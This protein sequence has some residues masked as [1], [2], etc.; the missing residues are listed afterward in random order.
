MAEIKQYID[1]LKQKQY[2]AIVN[3]KEYKALLKDMSQRISNK[4]KTA[5]NEATIESYFD[6]ELFAF[7]RDIFKPLGFEYNP[8]KEA[9][10]STKRHVTKGRADTS[11][12]ALVIEFKQPS[13]FSSKEQKN[14]AINQISEY[15]I[16]LDFEGESVGFVTDGT[17]CCFI[18]KN[19]NGLMR[20]GV[21]ELSFEQLDRLVQSIIR[22]S[23]TALTSKNI[24]ENFCNPPENDGI[25]FAL[26]K[27]LYDNLSKAITPKTQM[28]FNEWKELFNLAHDDVSKQQ[29]I[30]DRKTS[31]ENL[32]GK[33]FSKNDEEYT[34]L[35]AL[36]TAYAIIVKIV[37]Y[38]ILSIVRYNASLIDFETLVDCDSEALRYQ[39]ALLEEGAIF[40][41]Y[42]IT[43][44]LEGD[45]F[46]WYAAK[47]QW[48]IDISKSIADVF[49]VLSK[50]SDKAVLNT[51]KNSCDFFK[52][53]YQGMM[54]PAVRHS[55]GEYYTK[56]WLAHY[57]VDEALKLSK[58]ANWKGLDPCCGSGT[59]I[60]VMID[61]V[62]EETKRESA[63]KQLHEVLNRVKGIDLNP[64]AV[65]TARVNYF[66]NI[67]H[68]LK[69]DEELEIPIYL[70]DSSYV[71]EKCKFDGIDCLEY[72][73]NTLVSPIN[74]LV[75]ACMVEDPLKFSKSMT[76][77]ELYI[78]AL[79]EK[80]TYDCL[81]KLVK[82]N[83]LTEKIEK[84]LRKLSN[85]LVDLER[86]KWNG[87]W[88]R[89]I[90]NYLT[91][92]NL[93][94]FDIIVGNPPWVDWK[95]LPS[96]YR[97]KIKSL[98]ISRKLFS[99]D[100][101]TG[102][103]NLNICALISNV[104]T[105][106]W[107]ANS[108]ILGFL[109]PEPLIS[110]QS[111]EGFRNMFL[112]DDSRLYFKK[113][114]NWTKAG[115]PFK[116]VTQKFLT[117]Y[118]TK[119][120]VDYKKGVDVDWFILKKRK[121]YDNC[122]TLSL[123]EYFDVHKGIAA[124]CHNTK[125]FFAYVDSRQQLNEF[126]SIAGESQY[127]GREG[128]EFYPQ[129]MMIFEESGLPPTA[130]CTSLRNIQIKKAK[131]HIP[132][133]VE[134]LETKYLHPL[135]KG[136]D[137]YPFHIKFSGYI[138]PFPYDKRN[139]RVPIKFE[140]LIRTAPK[141][142][143]FYQ[144]HKDLILA[145]TTYNERIIGKKGEFYKLARVGAYSFAENYVVFRDN[146]RWGAAV[147]SSIDTSWGGKKRPLFQNHAVS[148]CED[149]EGNFISLEE[150]HFICGI[151]NTPVAFQYVINSS[152]SRSFPI[153]PR[154]YIPK[155]DK[156]NPIH[157]KIS[158]LSQEAHEKFDNEKAILRIV[159]QLN[160]LYLKISKF[161]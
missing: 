71:P 99:G 69:S 65:L 101:V 18:V 38:R 85:A 7:F 97:D 55:L 73:I 24:V 144:K 59:F 25:A 129:E 50:Y 3:S 54:P 92:A 102:G 9:S 72:S 45:F 28:L 30:I 146:T 48:S 91:T 56:Q 61:K 53:L 100:K 121:N 114:T 118:M 154:I 39:L 52:E 147:V 115:N 42:G 96:G 90:T 123:D 4:A 108:G 8:V 57:V 106:N 87:I 80:G 111:Y 107:L 13:T 79:D 94:K 70:G 36:Q 51:K 120:P 137:I 119:E 93:G 127:I 78:K 46:S 37:A 88:A 132:Q 116:P 1:I 112:S 130:D 151:M 141:L 63:E 31:L 150:A 60:T 34:A 140:E 145:Q 23:L 27:V 41:D 122:E 126:M 155:Y 44:L 22:L 47:E 17:K 64:V 160:D 157:K 16:G 2:I 49:K 12:G 138:V 153:R 33:T 152:D 62:L 156:E 58:T 83:E 43:N 131:Y 81:A 158:R 143:A 125:N 117:F 135:V 113:F 161:K 40:R 6:C 136:V 142:A 11:I 76:N 105:E 103:I 148:I 5:P 66:I 14:K 82:G 19:E 35:F 109:M 124:T 32:I 26:V 98:C 139:T 68:L 95:S 149:S 128:I 67:S 77:I 89:I 75:P 159:K 74:I 84:E 133:T 15:L 104:A 86:R 134:L 21:Y 10:V 110:Q 20:E 29:A